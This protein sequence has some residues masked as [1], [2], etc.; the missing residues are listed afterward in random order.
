MPIGICIRR[1]FVIPSP[2]P[3]PTKLSLPNVTVSR[4][5]ATTKRGCYAR[6]KMG[7]SAHINTVDGIYYEF[8]WLPSKQCVDCQL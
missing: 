7:R 1:G 8:I 2:R 4:E 5:S 6:S 3:T